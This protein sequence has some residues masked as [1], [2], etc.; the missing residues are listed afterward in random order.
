MDSYLHIFHPSTYM[1]NTALSMNL[2][3]SQMNPD[4]MDAFQTLSLPAKCLWI[5]KKKL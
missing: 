1:Y 3:K 2:K 4:P 5:E